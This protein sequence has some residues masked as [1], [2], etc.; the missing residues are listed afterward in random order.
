MTLSINTN[1]QDPDLWTPDGG[2]NPNPLDP[3]QFKIMFS[4][5]PRYT[6]SCQEI[7]IPSVDIQEVTFETSKLQLSNI[8]EKVEYG[9]FPMTFIIDENM[10]NYK[11]VYKW[12]L[13]ITSTGNRPN[14]E[15]SSSSEATIIVGGKVAIRIY[16]VWPTSLGQVQFLSTP[17]IIQYATCPSEWNFDYFEFVDQVELPR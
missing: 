12:M 15:T 5:I 7:A 8:G 9:R 6:F 4:R 17:N 10:Y 3:T 16:N 14:P 13:D 11:E 1:F 2:F